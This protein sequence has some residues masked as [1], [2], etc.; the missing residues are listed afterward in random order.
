MNSLVASERDLAV[1]V[2]GLREAIKVAAQPDNMFEIS[3]TARVS[4]FSNRQNAK[5]SAAVVQGL[6]DI[7][8][9]HNLA[10]DRDE[11]NQSLAFLDQQLKARESSAGSRAAPGRVRARYLGL[12]PAKLDRPALGRR[13][14]PICPAQR[15]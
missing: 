11:A 4:G 3:A 12:L 8:V 14:E 6:L 2:A 10:G 1:Q 5:L 7:F 15:S 9:E 13:A